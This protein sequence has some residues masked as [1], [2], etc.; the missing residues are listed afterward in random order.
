MESVRHLIVGAGISGLAT[1]AF[2]GADEDYLV[3][4]ADSEIG[5][6]CKTVKRDGFTWDYSGHFFHFKHPDV[7][8]WLRDRMPG[9]HI[10]TVEKKSFISY[11][12]RMIDFPFQKNIHQLPQDELI[13]CL[14]DVYMARAPIPGRAHAPE[15][16]FKEMLYG[17]FGRGIAE[18]FLIP[19]N[20]KLYACDLATLDKDAMGRFFPH[21]AMGIRLEPPAQLAPTR[22]R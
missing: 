4:E 19:Y 16:N 3:L 17:R 15:N 14:H 22:W 18:K 20:E 6:Y 13:E 2:L 21:N 9:Q 5:G 8:K 12:G 11:R 7:E 1:A 10:R